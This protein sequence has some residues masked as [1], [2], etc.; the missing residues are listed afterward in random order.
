MF[1][2]P[3]ASVPTPETFVVELTTRCNHDCLHCYNCWKQPIGYPVEELSTADTLA[4]LDKLIDETGAKLITLS[5]GEPLLRK[6]VLEII[7]HLHAR[8]TQLNLICNGSLLSEE[9]IDRIGLD[10]ISVWEL[11]LLSVERDIHDRLSG[12]PGAF[13][14]STEAMADL[15]LRRQVVVGVFVATLLNLDTWTETL[16]LA[17]ALG[18]DGV[19]FNRFNPGGRGLDNL[20]LLQAPPERVQQALD[21]ADRLCGEYGI[22]VSCSIAM[23]PCLFD[24]ERYEHLTFGFCAAGTERAYYAV[25][26]LGNLS[27]CNHSPTILGNIREDTFK[28]IVA[29]PALK[30]FMEARPAL[31][32]GCR[33]ERECQG[34]CKAAGEVAT[35]SPADP[36][37]FLRAFADR[38][39]KP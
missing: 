21:E 12:L 2:K 4:M 39:E 33:L 35:G 10:A 37:P 6:D 24:T 8:G 3:K 13:D 25:D 27:P 28:D 20:A 11:P 14:K 23:P 15:K 30:A 7:D 5:G 16:E 17:V 32:A 31:C 38:M 29:R 19:M 36:D 22:P 26:P 34:G 18:L 1:R 9:T